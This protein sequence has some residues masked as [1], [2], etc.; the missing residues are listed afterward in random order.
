M[1]MMNVNSVR[2]MA[3]RVGHV[4]IQV[5]PENHQYFLCGCSFVE[6]QGLNRD[7]ASYNR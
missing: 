2:I 1:L 4:E 3:E 5:N 6:A 7:D